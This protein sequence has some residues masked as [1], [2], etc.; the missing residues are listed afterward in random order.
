MSEPV[1]VTL[2]TDAAL[3]V[4]LKAK[5]EGVADDMAKL[6]RRGVHV[7]FNIGDPSGQGRFVLVEFRAQR[8]EDLV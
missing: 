3:A 7:A 8:I 6:K 4:A 1:V 2:E 5:L